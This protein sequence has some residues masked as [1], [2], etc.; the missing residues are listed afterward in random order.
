MAILDISEYQGN[1]SSWATLK[2]QVDGVILRCGY[3]GYGSSGT[4][5]KDPTF[6]TKNNGCKSANIDTGVYFFSQAITE[7]EARQEANFAIDLY[8]KTNMRLPIFFDTEWGNNKHTGRADK[9]TRDQRTKI[10][11]AF[12][13]EVERHGYFASIYASAAWFRDMLTMSKVAPY[14]KWVAAYDGVSPTKFGV[15]YWYL[16]QYTSK[17]RVGAYGSA[18]LDLSNKGSQFVKI[19][20]G[21]AVIPASTPTAPAAKPDAIPTV[22]SA[23]GVNVVKK[24]GKWLT[25]KD[26]KPVIYN[27]VAY[28]PENKTWWSCRNGTVNFGYTG[29]DYNDNGWWYCKDGWVDFG[30]KG[31]VRNAYGRWYIQNGHL[32]DYDE[33]CIANEICFGNNTYGNGIT[34]RIKLGKKYNTVQKYI[35]LIL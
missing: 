19:S 33:Q 23:V 4:L 25:E 35:N 31:I 5:K 10:A 21:Q 27:G 30:Y 14:A 12:C 6:E 2:N 22:K 3:R 1:P 32:D 20:N 29:L 15:D 9:L 26:G 28:N 18:P 34:R 8:K 7:A 16:H 17:G 24:N 11:I 13:E